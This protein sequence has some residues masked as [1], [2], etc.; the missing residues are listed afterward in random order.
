[1]MVGKDTEGETNETG[2]HFHKFEYYIIYK[3]G[4]QKRMKEFRVCSLSAKRKTTL[5]SS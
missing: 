3:K 5:H 1:M 2:L 4:S